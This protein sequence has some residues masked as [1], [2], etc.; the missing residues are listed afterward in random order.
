VTYETGIAHDQFCSAGLVAIEMDLDQIFNHF[1]FTALD[2]RH[3]HGKR[4]R[5][6]SKFL[7]SPRKG[8]HPG[9]MNNVFAGKTSDIRA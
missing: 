5:F 2:T 9:T 7:A 8:C 6:Q 1:P 3:I 4:S